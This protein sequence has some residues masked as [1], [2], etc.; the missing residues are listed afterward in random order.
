MGTITFNIKHTKKKN[1]IHKN[2]KSLK[3]L[4]HNRNPTHLPQ[5]YEIQTNQKKNPLIKLLFI[6]STFNVAF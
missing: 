4:K 2:I 6:I 3:C 5:I 1:K